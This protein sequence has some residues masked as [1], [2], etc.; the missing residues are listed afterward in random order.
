MAGKIPGKISHKKL[1][2]FKIV[3]Q[4]ILVV[5]I[6]L[7]QVQDQLLQVGI[8]TGGLREESCEI[9]NNFHLFMIP[10]AGA[11]FL[12]LQDIKYP[13]RFYTSRECRLGILW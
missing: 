9:E 4:Q 13:R 10:A 7:R 1:S 8:H 12:N 11:A 2:V 6:N 3:A 5:P